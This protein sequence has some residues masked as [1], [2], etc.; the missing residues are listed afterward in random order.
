MSRRSRVSSDKGLNG[1]GF[2]AISAALLAVPLPYSALYSCHTASASVP[3]PLSAPSPP[4]MG[5]P[6]LNK[7][8]NPSDGDPST[9]SS[10]NGES[11]LRKA[12]ARTS[13]ASFIH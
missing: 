7:R 8:L 9:V 1:F 13:D 12:H 11:H 3:T 10:T 5:F 2:G 4:P 6:R